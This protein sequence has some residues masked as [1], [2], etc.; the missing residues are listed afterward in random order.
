[1][2]ATRTKLPLEIGKVTDRYIVERIE[3]IR[4][5]FDKIAEGYNEYSH[6]YVLTFG[7]E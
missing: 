1:M 2:S 7:E 6:G 4:P 3:L 5:V